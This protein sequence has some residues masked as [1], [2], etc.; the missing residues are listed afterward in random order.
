V[1]E[2]TVDKLL[3][4]EPYVAR[5]VWDDGTECGA[6]IDTTRSTQPGA[7]RGGTV[8]R[9]VLRLEETAPPSSPARI[10]FASRARSFE[11][12]LEP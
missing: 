4:W 6:E 12:A 5:A 1:V 11:V 10:V 7:V 9:L 8:V 2:I 3:A